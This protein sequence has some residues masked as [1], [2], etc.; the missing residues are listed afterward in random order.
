MKHLFKKTFL[1]LF[2]MGG[3]T[4]AWSETITIK[5]LSGISQTGTT[6]PS[7]AGTTSVADIVTANNLTCSTPVSF[8]ESR[9]RQLAG[10]TSSIAAE[11]RST[12]TTK[13][14]VLTTDYLE[15][16]IS[17]P[18]GYRFTPTSIVASV[19]A[20]GTNNNGAA[21][22]EQGT[23][24]ESDVSSTIKKGSEGGTQI[25]CSPTV[26][27]YNNEAYT[28]RLYIGCNTDTKG[29]EIQDVVLAGTYEVASTDP[30]PAVITTQ[31]SN[32]E[33]N[34]G[35]E[36]TLTVA[37]SGYPAPT[38]QWYS[39]DDAEKTN[40]AAIDGATSSSYSFTP[41]ATGTYYYYVT[42]TNENT[43]T[44]VA[45]NVVT[46]TVSAGTTADPTFTVYGNT[47]QLSCATADAVIYYELDNADVK[48][49]ETK[50][51]YSG[52]FI[53]A[54]SGTIYAYAQKAGY[55]ASAVVSKAVTLS[56]VG[57]VVG[58]LIATIQAAKNATTTVFNDITV[59]SPASPTWDGRGSYVNHMKVNGEVT[60]T[61]TNGDIIKSIK[62][63][64]TS[65]DGSKVA[66][67]TVGDGATVVTTP[68]E[69]M[70][71]DVQVGGVQTMTEVVIT[72]DEPT[73]NNSITF[74]LGRES[75]LY[76]E[77]YGEDYVSKTITSV[78]WATFCSSSIVDPS[79]VDGLTAYIV[80]GGAGGVLTK[81][82]VTGA[83]PANTG[84]LLK[85]DAGTYNIPVAATSTFDVSG[86]KLEGVT[87][88]TPISANAG[89][90]LMAT[91]TNGLGFYKNENEFTVGANTAY[92][93]AGFDGSGARL[94]FNL[95]DPA[96][97]INSVKGEELMVNGSEI[98][99]L[100]GQRVA[101]P[102]KGL[103]IINGKKVMVK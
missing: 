88:D 7:Y 32:T 12:N 69:L 101:Q 97:G 37:A 3:A 20:N 87:A 53:P 40:A 100:Q 57:E 84:L 49:S 24:P 28:F 98:Y 58:D 74:T 36:T 67:V 5:W 92:L 71:R 70:P 26:K 15:F 96:T 66:T 89:Y 65:N 94:Y 54:S 62:I 68:A 39:C 19:G 75:R 14:K 42:A 102:A 73:A 33:A 23:Y 2:L 99:N 47:V 91:G 9:N 56:T 46:V 80:T 27:A 34:V 95:E 60:L 25:S 78:G 18:S 103:Y 61:A 21:L 16:S 63:F 52:A 38:Y 17:I 29:V 10:A 45:S 13:Q 30:A 22:Y 1:L 81:T 35:V 55:N 51:T 44:P 48:T 72:V 79:N 4:S 43:A 50:S 11:F 41:A 76:I 8:A 6:A 86:N 85:G 83:V 77:V 59:T 93:P 82:E 31:P 90:V 64:G